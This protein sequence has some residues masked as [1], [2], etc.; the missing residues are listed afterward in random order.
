MLGSQCRFWVVHRFWVVNRLV[1]GGLVLWWWVEGVGW[2]A[3]RMGRARGRVSG[4]G[5][6]GEEYGVGSSGRGC[7]C[8]VPD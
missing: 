8:R 5:C 6:D 3:F 7:G 1:L 4:G 2:D